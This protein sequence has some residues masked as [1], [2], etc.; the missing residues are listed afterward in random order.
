MDNLQPIHRK[1]GGSRV[2]QRAEFRKGYMGPTIPAPPQPKK[3][4][5]PNRIGLSALQ[6]QLLAIVVIALALAVVLM[7]FWINRKT[8][9]KFNHTKPQLPRSKPGDR[10][11]G[12]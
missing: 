12:I 11:P 9:Q 7:G 3:P 2:N 10:R 4:K 8:G 1:Q 6:G 5:A